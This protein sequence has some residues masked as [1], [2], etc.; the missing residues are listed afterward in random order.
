MTTFT[1]TRRPFVLVAALLGLLLAVSACSAGSSGSTADKAV[2]P[3]GPSDGRDGATGGGAAPGQSGAEP[4][5]APGAGSDSGTAGDPG[6][7][8]G[9][10][11]DG[12]AVPGEPRRIR[13]GSVTVQ[14]EELERAAQQVRDIAASLRGYVSDENIGIAHNAW[15]DGTDG[16]SAQEP[17]TDGITYEESQALAAETGGH[18]PYP[19]PG[20]ARLVVRVPT[21]EMTNAMNQLA[22]VGKELGRWSSETEVE[23][24][25]VDLESRVATQT[26][27][28]ARVRKLMDQATSIAD[29]VALENELAKREANL[30][31]LKAQLDSLAGQAA[32]ATITVVLQTP[33]RVAHLDEENGFLGGLRA[34]WLAL[35]ASTTALLTV[36]GAL[37][38]F[39]FVAAVIG[40]PLL[41]WRRRVRAAKATASTPVGPAGP[42]TA[43]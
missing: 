26:A 2:A 6:T 22:G 11:T 12:T 7:K 40:L 8:S 16:G 23:T 15:F 21:D 39:L 19:G 25:L 5:S 37:L 28:V 9:P 41:A 33:E 32:M 17:A 24:A 14:V 35:V 1:R 36:V 18:R 4:G 38:P 30:E 27:S 29:V 31:S 20:Q 43:P 42:P 13:R 3:A 34:G 10:G